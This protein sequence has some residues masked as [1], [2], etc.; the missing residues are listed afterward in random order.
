M[1]HFGVAIHKGEVRR[2][3]VIICGIMVDCLRI[4]VHPEHRT[5]ETIPMDFTEE[6]DQRAR[7]ILSGLA[8]ND[9][10]L[11]I[12]SVVPRPA[13]PAH[14]SVHAEAA[15]PQYDRACSIQRLFV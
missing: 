13:V 12:G 10:T 15:R 3:A 6:K 9:V 11:L 14:I 2:L 5:A 8:E 7:A 4:H 1:M